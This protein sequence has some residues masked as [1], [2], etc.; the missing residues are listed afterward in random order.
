VDE[1]PAGHGIVNLFGFAH[2]TDDA[3]QA[4]I[5]GEADAHLSKDVSLF[6]R[7]WLGLEDAGRGPKVAGDALAGLRI[8]F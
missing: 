2:G 3:F 8:R 6:G 4:G 5:G 1:I 7:G